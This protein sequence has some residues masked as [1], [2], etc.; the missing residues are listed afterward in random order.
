MRAGAR[1]GGTYQGAGAGRG[2][3]G[4]RAASKMEDE[5]VAESW[6]EA[7]DSGVRR[8]RRPGAG[9]GGTWR[10]GSLQGVGLRIVI[11][12]ERPHTPGRRWWR[13]PQSLEC[14]EGLLKGPRS[15]SP[16]TFARC[17]SF[18]P[19]TCASPGVPHPPPKASFLG[20]RARSLAPGPFDPSFPV[21]L[22]RP[23]HHFKVHVL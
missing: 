17:T 1:D 15:I 5:E 11:P 12:K 8:S 4:G 18:H 23:R 13:G 2:L 3:G 19:P 9:P 14:C 22:S 10:E 21:G 16:S 20:P 7:A 6:E